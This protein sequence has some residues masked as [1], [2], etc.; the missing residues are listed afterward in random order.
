MSALQQLHKELETGIWKALQEEAW[1]REMKLRKAMWQTQGF[2]QGL[3][4]AF[5]AVCR[6]EAG[7]G[8][9]EQVGDGN[10][11]PRSGAN[12]GNVQGQ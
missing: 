3:E 2:R 5:E 6:I 1:W 12:S 11:T 7:G 9:A 10:A 8:G 4:L